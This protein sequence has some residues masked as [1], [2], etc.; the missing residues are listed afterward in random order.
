MCCFDE[1]GIVLVRRL[2][3]LFSCCFFF[4]F[5]LVGRDLLMFLSKVVKDSYA[6]GA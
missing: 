3:L 4:F 5:C 2:F 1:L 6:Y